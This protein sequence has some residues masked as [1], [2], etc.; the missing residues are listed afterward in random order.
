HAEK[1]RVAIQAEA[2]GVADPHRLA[3]KT[4]Y[5]RRPLARLTARRAAPGLIPFHRADRHRL[6]LGWPADHPEAVPKLGEAPLRTQAG[7]RNKAKKRM[8]FTISSAAFILSES[9][10]VN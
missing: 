3:L 2:G 1:P 6:L 9:R 4:I 7:S 5:S 8:S 10:W